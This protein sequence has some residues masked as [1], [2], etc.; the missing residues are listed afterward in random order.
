VI[1]R[2]TSPT[3]SE[4]ADHDLEA[5]RAPGYIPNLAGRPGRPASAC[6]SRG[7]L[8]HRPPRCR[9]PRRRLARARSTP[10]SRTGTSERSPRRS[11]ST[12][13]DWSRARARLTGRR[14]G[15]WRSPSRAPWQ[16]PRPGSPT[17]ATCAGKKRHLAGGAA[18]AGSAPRWDSPWP[19]RPLTWVGELSFG[20]G[21]RVNQA[22]AGAGPRD[23]EAVLDES[24]LHGASMHSVEVAG[25]T[26]LVTRSASGDLCA[27]VNTWQ[28]LRRAAGRRRSRGGHRGL[29]RAPRHPPCLRDTR[30]RT[31]G[32]A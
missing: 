28:S 27:I 11:R 14:T 18:P 19:G 2:A 1:L 9:P 5:R 20:M 7:G 29:R 23:F 31:E 13:P 3:G 16:P 10:R 12:A 21:V 4:T 15:H 30:T 25:E 32:P 8:R 22:Q 26:V 6:R 17:G 24:Q